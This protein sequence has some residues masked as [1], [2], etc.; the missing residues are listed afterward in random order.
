MVHIQ[1][2]DYDNNLRSTPTQ[3]IKV[4]EDEDAQ[5]YDP[6]IAMAITIIIISARQDDYKV[7]AWGDNDDE[8][9]FA[10]KGG[11]DDH[12]LWFTLVGVGGDHNLGSPPTQDIKG[13]NRPYQDLDDGE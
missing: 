3:D 2:N 7:V 8:D 6:P 4:G 9:G 1:N 13:V 5:K 11:A 12:I 10:Y